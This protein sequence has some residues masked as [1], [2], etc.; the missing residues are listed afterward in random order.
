MKIG[1]GR[2]GTG[3]NVGARLPRQ[4]FAAQGKFPIG[5]CNT[6]QHRT[7]KYRLTQ[8]VVRS[9]IEPGLGQL[10][11]DY[12][13]HARDLVLHQIAKLPLVIVAVADQHQRCLEYMSKTIHRVAHALAATLLAGQQ[14]IDVVGEGNQ[15]IRVA[16]AQLIGFAPLKAFY[17]N[18]N[19]AQRH[20]APANN[21]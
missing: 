11:F 2:N 10:A 9:T 15:F 14:N 1:I 7:N 16:P 20:Q 21:D 19:S 5:V 13:Q 4:L 8:N 6:L 3:V 18:S 17:S 12:S